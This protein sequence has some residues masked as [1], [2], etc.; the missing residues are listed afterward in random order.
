MAG[1]GNDSDI[2]SRTG[3]KTKF[4]ILVFIATIGTGDVN[5]IEDGNGKE[6]HEK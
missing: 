4:V 3:Q 6:K 2:G 5:R 1:G